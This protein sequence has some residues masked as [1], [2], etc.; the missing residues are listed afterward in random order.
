VSTAAP[1]R[2]ILLAAGRGTRLRALHSGPKCLLEIDGQSLLERHLRALAALGVAQ[3]GIVTGH[4]AAALER[5]LQDLAGLSRPALRFNPDFERGSVLSLWCA[6]PW[7]VAG[8]DVLLMD[9]DVLYDP[10]VLARLV[11]SPGSALLLD[12]DYDDAGGEAVKVCVRAGRVVEFRKQLCPELR[13][14]FAGESVGFFRFAPSDA[15]RL[16]AR[17][18]DYVRAGRMDEPCEEVIRDLL[19]EAPERYC[20]REVTGLAWLEI[21][22]PKDVARARAEILPRIPRTA[23]PAGPR[24]A[25]AGD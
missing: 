17:A 9:A 11:R 6:S 14:D 18:Y 22:F 4:E 21:D 3:I 19:L 25:P 16:A 7:L 5:A 1:A 20:A 15:K 13:F 8:G 2:A 23:A 12:R 24:R 10:E